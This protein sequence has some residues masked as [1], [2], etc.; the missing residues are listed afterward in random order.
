MSK[1]IAYQILY[2]IL[3]KMYQAVLNKDLEQL[4]ILKKQYE[5]KRTAAYNITLSGGLDS[6]FD[7]C[8]N[9]CVLSLGMGKNDYS[10]YVTNIAKLLNEIEIDLKNL[11]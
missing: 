3:K 2:L 10:K 1:K 11:E 4:N 5:N 7:Q 8:A 6:K 9:S